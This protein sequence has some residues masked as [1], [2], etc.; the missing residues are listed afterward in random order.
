MG[1]ITQ[2]VS[3]QAGLC[4]LLS[5]AG[6]SLKLR[7]S[8]PIELRAPVKVEEGNRLW[9]GEVRACEADSDGYTIEVESDLM[10]RD[11]AATEHMAS[12]F[13]RPGQEAGAG[14]APTLRRSNSRQNK[15]A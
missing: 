11:V 2:F 3:K 14:N 6:P 5:V 13:R 12:H 10:F 4:E 7:T 9:M 8:L 15:D 1:R